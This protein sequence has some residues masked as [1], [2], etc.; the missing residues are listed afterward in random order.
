MSSS[1]KQPKKQL[2]TASIANQHSVDALFFEQHQDY[3]DRKGFSAC[4]PEWW[5]MYEGRQTP[6]G[7]S[8]DLPRATENICGWVVDSQ[9]A[10][11]LGTTVTLNF[12]CF[13][14]NIS[15]DGLKKFDEYVQKSIKMN[16]YC[17]IIVRDSL[18]GAS[19]FLYHYWSDDI[20][21]I[22]GKSKGSLALDD[23]ALEDFACANPRLDSIQRQKWVGFK[24]RMEVK[25]VRATVNRNMKDYDRVISLITPDDY[26]SRKSAYDED[27]NLFDRG[28]CTVMTRFFRIDGEVYWVRSTKS[29]TL[30]EPIPLNP[31]L[32]EKKLKI[33]PEYDLDGYNPDDEEIYELD[34]EIEPL[35]DEELEDADDA[36]HKEAKE[37]FSLYPIAALTLIPRRNCLYGRSVI[38][39]IE[40]NQKIINFIISMM[41]KEIQDT[42]WATIIMKEG[43]ANG[44]V[45]TGQPGGMFTDFTPGNN[46]GIKRLEGNQL[47]GQVM[48]YVTTI[49]DI[50]KMITGTNELVDSSSNL[51]DVTAYALQI[52]EEQRN[53]RIEVL[54]N[55]YWRFLVDCAEIR[56][57]F[58]KHY[59]PESYYIYELTD[60]EFQEEQQSYENMLAHPDEE[61][62]ING[63]M[64]KQG[65]IAAKKGAP[66]KVQRKTIDP[67]EELKGH[68]FDIVCEPGKGT[69][70]SEIIDTDLIN[71][72]FLNGGYEKMSADSFEMWLN[73]N[74]LMSESKKADIRVL[75][76]KQR[77]SENF[78]LKQQNQELTNMLQM[79]LSRVKQ[80]EAVV[81]QKEAIN[82]SMN[83]SFNE[84]M[85]AAK[86][87][88]NIRDEEIRRL[89]G[90]GAGGTKL[91][92][93][94]EMAEND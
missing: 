59:Y 75:I 38:E 36:S 91:P 29:V 65:E 39:G 1:K 71:N 49:I 63:Q 33:K 68:I 93:A 5:A 86:E 14:K 81:G 53:K 89:K 24:K 67:A 61:I 85:A 92:S 42:A 56:L 23:I 90:Q 3:M 18:V 25:A 41:A 35:Q 48:N 32:T 80:L 79:V 40:D 66:S 43:A 47:N 34:P 60:A 50:T 11:I 94:E 51:K 88:V 37:K 69:K 77:Q 74:P 70:Y 20:T 30:C 78:Q 16:Q 22:K 46:F 27:E 13:D 2:P 21:L 52:L 15:T 26:T 12:T 4:I 76:N 62:N 44:Q 73:L 6:E 55:R 10:T 57:Q 8:D 58:Y 87:Q 72:L 83:K 19:G 84:S 64:M 7:Y 82:Q 31:N 28:L 17:D 45:W 9:H 54:Q